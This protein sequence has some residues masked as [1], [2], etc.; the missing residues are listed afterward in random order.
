MTEEK[1]RVLLIGPLPPPLGGV[2]ILFQILTEDLS[3]RDDVDSHTV[4]LSGV[5]V[6][7]EGKR[8]ALWMTAYRLPWTLWKIFVLAKNAQVITLHSNAY[9]MHW[10]A[11]AVLA[12]G[13][14]RHRP[15]F[16]RNIGGNDIR[17]SGWASLKI[18]LWCMRKADF[19]TVETKHILNIA[20]GLGSDVHWM[21]NSRPMP[22]DDLKLQ[23]RP[24]CR[25]F[26]Y[27]GHIRTEKGLPEIIEA[28]ERFAGSEDIA[29]DV[30][31]SLRHD[32]AE[33][34]FED[35]KKVRFC[36][37]V[38]Y[39]ALFDLLTSYDAL[40]LPSYHDGEGYPGIVFDAYRTG[41]PV[42]CTR[43]QAL[44]EIVDESSGI[45]IEP[46]DAD[47]LYRAMRRMTD[48]EEYY[49]GLRQGVTKRR[50]EFSSDYWNDKFVQFCRS[51]I[52]KRK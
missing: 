38:A 12:I 45:L 49:M 27:L 43:W 24:T 11:V 30:Y 44:P 6:D 40:L 28:G 51:I 10:L 8:I 41:M 22:K 32:I 50:E 37:S 35:L 14:L 20:R 39:E 26:V 15:V 18:W 31:G 23:P 36:G 33:K 47:A 5:R 17:Q 3:A 34:D 25:R 19:A 52:D 46:H 16:L 48:D 7:A 29:V 42:I 21:A 9:S 13:K 2:R 1:L 4:N